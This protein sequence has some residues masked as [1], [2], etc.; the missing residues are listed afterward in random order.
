MR[1]SEP[2]MALWFAIH[3]FRPSSAVALLRRMDLQG[4]PLWRDWFVRHYYIVKR[5]IVIGCLLVCLA[6]AVLSF[7]PRGRASYGAPKYASLTL[8]GFTNLPGV[9]PHAI[10]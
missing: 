2:G 6:A 1:Y 8:L 10:F 7:W 9:G 5:V 3:A 4:L